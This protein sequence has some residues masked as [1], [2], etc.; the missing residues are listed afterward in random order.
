MHFSTL[1]LQSI[2]FVFFWPGKY[3]LRQILAT[4]LIFR[5]YW[6]LISNGVVSRHEQRSGKSVLSSGVMLNVFRPRIYLLFALA[7]IRSGKIG[8][9]CIIRYSRQHSWIGCKPDGME[10]GR[11]DRVNV[12]EACRLTIRLRIHLNPPNDIYPNFFRQWTHEA[13]NRFVLFNGPFDHDWNAVIHE[14]RA[15]V[16]HPLAFRC[17]SQRRYGNIGFLECVPML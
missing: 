12:S 5:I 16:N 13:E 6:Q 9:R 2:Y 14:R 10:C 3:I 1:F 7:S 15:E 17:Y 8:W 4:R 11:N